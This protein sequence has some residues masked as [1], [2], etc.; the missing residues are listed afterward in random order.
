MDL[1][2]CY[3][4]GSLVDTMSPFPNW[5][6]LSSSLGFPHPSVHEGRARVRRDWQWIYWCPS[7]PTWIKH[8]SWLHNYTEPESVNLLRVPRNRFPAWRA[9]TITL[10]DVPSRQAIHRLAESIPTLLPNTCSVLYPYRV[11]SSSHS[12]SIHRVVLFLWQPKSSFV[13]VVYHSR[14]TCFAFQYFI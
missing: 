4:H 1:C 7:P 10:F 2:T 8:L 13:H 6:S 14:D 12:D 9:G 11:W 3:I 5:D